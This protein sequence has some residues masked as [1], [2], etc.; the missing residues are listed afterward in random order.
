MYEQFFGL[1]DKPFALTPNPRFVFYSRQYREAEG[2]LLYG[3][4]GGEGFM[5]VTGQ[6]GTGKTTLCRDLIEKL[7]RNKIHS[8][9]LFNPFL[10]GVE[11]LAALLSE[12]G[13]T[14]PPRGTRKDLLER[15]NQF[16]L[17][18]LVLGKRCVAIFDEA[19]HLS[20]EF[21]EQ[22]RVLSNLETDQEKL[23]QIVLVG[24]PE[25][26]DRIRTPSMAQLDQRVSIRCTLTDLDAHETDRYLH[27]RL[28][29]AGARGQVRV[30]PRAVAEIFRASHGVPRL[31]NL[32]C[33]RAL[34]AAYAEQ[35]RDIGPQH[36]R[37]GVMAL[38]GEEAELGDSGRS[39]SKRLRRR[40]ALAVAGLATVAAAAAIAWYWP[41][42]I[43]TP[44]PEALYWRAT[45]TG[46]RAVAERELRTLIASNPQSQR[47]GDALLRLAQL[48]MERRDRAGA[49]QTLARLAAHAPTGPSHARALLLDA[50][51]R[52][53]DGDTT[54][55][56][57]G[58][59]SDLV[60]HVLGEVSL[61][62]DLQEI[63]SI[64][65]TRSASV[66]GAIAI[67][68]AVTQTSA[69]GSR[70]SV[71]ARQSPLTRDTIAARVP[72]TVAP[73][74]A[75]QIAAFGSDSAAQ[76]LKDRLAAF[77]LVAEVAPD[78]NVF[79]VRAGHYPSTAAAADALR[80]LA[81]KGIPGSIATD[82]TP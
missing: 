19:Q 78:G 7:D 12:F 55:A 24:Q 44:D 47:I 79:R 3:I 67:D 33:D 68:P 41:L 40:A 30:A 29:V 25:L 57:G 6:P 9:L 60:T 27:H 13:I 58:I 54:G 50:R 63:S 70:D 65:D 59:G 56:C 21:L 34:L 31:I 20:P 37:K 82:P 39:A 73:Q 32:V 76:S 18:Q 17:A 75:I 43:G 42:H 46:S 49:L 48:Q 62:R 77:G 72:M 26:L 66:G 51:V 5:L 22:I 64:C 11:M 2:Q 71:S 81:A 10:N 15:L 53:D 8:A 69:H 28:N 23:I 36:V 80:Q 74:Y 16:L 1:T 38:R 61:A 4:N 52:L 45:M 14:V 35:T